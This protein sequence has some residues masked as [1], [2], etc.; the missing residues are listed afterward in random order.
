MVRLLT[1]AGAQLNKQ[2]KVN[3]YIM[4]FSLHQNIQDVTMATMHAYATIAIND[5]VSICV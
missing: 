4:M 3:V 2:E 1:E 5:I